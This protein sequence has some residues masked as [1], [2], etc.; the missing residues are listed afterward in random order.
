MVTL[1]DTMPACDQDIDAPKRSRAA[2]RSIAKA[3]VADIGIET[4]HFG[5]CRRVRPIVVVEW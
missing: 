4:S 2:S 1:G 3:R 5:K